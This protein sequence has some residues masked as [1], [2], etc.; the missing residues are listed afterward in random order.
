MCIQSVSKD[1]LPLST[2]V[3]SHIMETRRGACPHTNGNAR[4]NTLLHTHTHHTCSKH[5][6]FRDIT[7]K[8]TPGL[9][10]CA[11][12]RSIRENRSR[13]GLEAC[14]L[15]INIIKLSC[16]IAFGS[17]ER[18]AIHKSLAVLP[19]KH[20]HAHAKSTTRKET[21]T[22]TCRDKSTHRH[23]LTHTHTHLDH[24]GDL[25]MKSNRDRT[26]NRRCFYFALSTTDLNSFI[27]IQNVVLSLGNKD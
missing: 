4:P 1:P 25:F 9:R 6:P 12:L 17:A 5:S 16:Q 13:T 7:S 3:R 14:G 22:N 20:T 2:R 19:L 8:L 21:D 27:H 26:R 11:E 10:H 24:L 18:T 23:T 15:E